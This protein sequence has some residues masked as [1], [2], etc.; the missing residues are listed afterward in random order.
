MEGGVKII[1]IVGGRGGQNNSYCG[2]GKNKKN[3]NIIVGGRG[4]KIILIVGKG[5]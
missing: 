3:K 1:I 5:G 2:E 4:L